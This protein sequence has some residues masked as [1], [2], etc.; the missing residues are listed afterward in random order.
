[1][2][3]AIFERLLVPVADS[4]DAQSTSELLAQM[5]AHL[6]KVYVVHIDSDDSSEETTH[7]EI[8]SPFESVFDD[9]I[10]LETTV[11]QCTDPMQAI[12]RVAAEYNPTAIAVHPRNRSPLRSFF[13]GTETTSLIQDTDAP[14][15]VLPSELTVSPPGDAF[16]LVVPLDGSDR[17]FEALTFAC[18]MFETPSIIALHVVSDPETE[19]YT[20]LTPHLS[21]ADRRTN[22]ADQA[23][24]RTLFER[25]S[26]QVA[27]YDVPIETY[28][29]GGN[30]S[31][32]IAQ[33]ATEL[34]ADG[35]VFQRSGGKSKS[36]KSQANSASD[37][38]VV[39]ETIT[40]LIT[41]APV[42]VYIR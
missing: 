15:V 16:S 40:T 10:R 21:T 20:E 2:P 12:A 39:G 35:I 19:L 29:L 24:I 9:R 5:S 8:F 7:D 36:D 31:K 25:A 37:I 38:A 41:D 4:D 1:M 34:D 32:A 42:P 3:D 14:V 33:T 11:E 30:V 22:L 23:E 18:T 17:A 13:T 26:E 6:T 28:T 27:E